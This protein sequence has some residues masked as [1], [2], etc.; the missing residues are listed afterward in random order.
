MKKSVFLF[1]LLYSIHSTQAQNWTWAETAGGILPDEA[2]GCAMDS[3]GN[4]YVSG[5]FFSS[6]IN[7]NS[8]NSLSNSGISEGFIVKYNTSGNSVWASRMKGSSEDKATGCAV[9]K[10]GNVI[11]TGY[12]NSSS[13]QFGGNNAHSINNSKSNGSFD[14]FIVKYNASGTPQWFYAIGKDDDDGGRSVAADNAGNVYV[15]GWY[16]AA[17]ITVGSFTL[18]NTNPAGGSSDVFLIKYS[19]TGNVLWA[20]SFGGPDDDKGNSCAVDAAGNVIVTGYFKP[21]TL[22]IEGNKFPN[23]GSK[24]FFVIKYQSDG[25]LLEAKTFGGSGGDEAFECSVD[26]AGNIYVCGGFSSSKIMFDSDSILNTGSSSGVFLVKLNSLLQTVWT[27]SASSNASDE[28]RSCSADKYGNV[29]ITGVFSGSSITFGNTVLN[30]NGDEEIFLVKYT[31]NGN[32]LWAK[33]IGKSKSDGANACSLHNSGKILVAGYYN[34]SSLTLGNIT[35]DN[36]Y[37]GVAT[38][39]VFVATTCSALTGTHVQTSCGPF[40]WIDGNTYSSSTN[41]VTLTKAGSANTCDSL[42]TLHL[43]VSDTVSTTIQENICAGQYYMFN[44]QQLTQAGYYFDTLTTV[45]GCDS[46]ISLYLNV[47]PVASSTISASICQGNSYN[48]N[49]TLLTNAGTYTQTLPGASVQGCDSTVTLNLT[50][51]SFIVNN[52]AEAICVGESY[53]FNG[54]TLTQSGVYTDTLTTAT[55][56][57]IVTLTLTVNALPQPT[58]TQNGNVLSTQT[59]NSYQWQL[60]GNYIQGANQQTYTTT[61]NGDYTVEVTDAN[62][63]SNTSSAVNVVI[64]ST[65]ETSDFRSVIYPNPASTNLMIETDE[66]MDEIKV[67]DVTG[68]ILI[69]QS[70]IQN[71]LSKIDIGKLAEA[72]YFIYIKTSSCR[73]AVKSFV[74]Y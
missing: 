71:L 19:P 45:A 32:Q 66:I 38:S 13:L 48:F 12:F 62:G 65:S 15:T 6:S 18:H 27:K 10:T 8:G 42:I 21:D 58:I 4:M 9:D 50:M 7:F 14:A 28:A 25:T 74:K 29:V 68:R 1:L 22:T 20:K 61:Q 64:S 30:N 17:S 72:T 26:G 60:N 47:L 3:A 16:R 59:F 36:S 46:F 49:G 73:T 52:I 44:G 51:D 57:S 23:K 41:T 39:D 63:C 35:L 11:V 53:V 2:N 54:K 31:A 24:D 56:D 69:H 40:T 5:F 70:K 33:K 55:C 34:S 37:V 43:T 67:A